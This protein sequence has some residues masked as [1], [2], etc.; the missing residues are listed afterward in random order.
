MF[1]LMRSQDHNLCPGE[2]VRCYLEQ[3]SFDWAAWVAAI[4]H[5]GRP[6]L[7]SWVSADSS[8]FLLFAPPCNG[9]VPRRC[10]AAW[11]QGRRTL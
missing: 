2:C 5:E 9:G 6:Y 4:D 10:G 1:R 8:L 3:M 7:P 11:L